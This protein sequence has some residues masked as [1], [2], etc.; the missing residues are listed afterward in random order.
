MYSSTYISPI[1]WLPDL[2]KPK[3]CD[4]FHQHQSF[5]IQVLKQIYY[6]TN[7]WNFKQDYGRYQLLILALSRVANVTDRSIQLTIFTVGSWLFPYL[8]FLGVFMNVYP[9][10]HPILV[11]SLRSLPVWSRSPAPPGLNTWLVEVTN[12]NP[13]EY[14]KIF[15]F[16][17]PEKII[18]WPLVKIILNGYIIKNYW[19]Q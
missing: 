4:K 1:Q 16:S 6:T 19:L 2:L 3:N 11:W 10:K 7:N 12:L 8:I 9:T 14:L 13:S 5:F 17:F 15:S 18:N